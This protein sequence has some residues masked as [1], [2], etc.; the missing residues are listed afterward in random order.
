MPVGGRHGLSPRLRPPAGPRRGVRGRHRLVLRR[1]PRRGA[2]RPRRPP[3][4]R[5][6]PRP[7]P[8]LGGHRPRLLRPRGRRLRRHR[9][10]HPPGR[11]AD[12]RDRD[13]RHARH[14]PRPLPGLPPRP[15]RQRPPARPLGLRVLRHQRP[16]V[17]PT[18]W[19]RACAAPARPDALFVLQDVFVPTVVECALRAGLS[20]PGDLRLATLGD[21]LDVTVDGVG[22]TAVAFDWEA[23]AVQGVRPARRAAR[24]PPSFPPGADRSPPPRRPRPLRRT[25]VRMDPRAAEG[26][27]VPGRAARPEILLR[28]HVGLAMPAADP[29][30]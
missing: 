24:R 20:V 22:M 28:I 13:A 10:P 7:P 25:P 2:R 11:E 5:R 18:C 1:L 27:G 6:G 21:D 8:R 14:H 29:D 30:V 12:R 26:H 3:D 15:L 23:L 9:G 4:P 17:A 16:G 19:R